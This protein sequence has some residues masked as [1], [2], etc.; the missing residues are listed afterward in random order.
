MH[1]DVWFP[2]ASP[3]AT[4]ELL[5]AVGREAE[6]RSV[7]AIWVGEHVV[8]MDDYA[9]DYPYAED[10]R[11]PL[12]PGTGLLEP[13]TTLTF[14]AAVTSRVRLATAV[15]LLPQ[16]NPVYTAKEVAT[17]DW[18]SQGRVDLG[19][20]VGWLREEFE[21]VGVPWERRGARTDD[22][23]GVLRSLWCDDPSTFAGEFYTLAP[24]HQYPK[25]VQDPHPPIH[26]GGESDAALRRTARFGRGWHT[27]NRLPADLAAPL[28][29]LDEL[30]AAEGR[31]RDEITV[32]VCP[33]FQEFSPATVDQYAAAG[34][35]AV[36]AL[37]FVTEPSDVPAAFDA[38]DP[39]ME[40]AR[41]S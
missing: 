1:F 35:D 26:I 17:L 19:V 41:A 15:C 27:F 29:R 4:A 30:L 37:L 16:R 38:L 24:C 33:Y 36:A 7:H 12:P 3:F 25:P 5:A 9:S 13:F 31:T 18:L 22:Y 10:G 34:A 6:E 32:T 20:G 8:T 2:A 21:A 14:L 28:A 39:L 40:R 23:L 11:L